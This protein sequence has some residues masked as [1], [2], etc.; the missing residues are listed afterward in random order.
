MGLN[1]N[2]K[3]TLHI[4]A[5][6]P[7]ANFWSVTIYDAATRCLIDNQQRNA[8]LSSRKDLIK[9][10]DGSVDLFYGPTKEYFDKRW[11]IFLKLNKRDLN[12]ENI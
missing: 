5:N 7:A 4:P 11:M 3:Y 10:D 8:D 2:D 12:S 1:G 6:S 9:N